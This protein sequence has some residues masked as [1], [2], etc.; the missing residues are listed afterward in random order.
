MK[1]IENG[2][3]PFQAQ[4]SPLFHKNKPTKN[5][6]VIMNIMFK[7]FIFNIVLTNSKILEDLNNK[8]IEKFG[9]FHKKIAKKFIFIGFF[10]N[11]IIV[12]SFSRLWLKYC[13]KSSG[14]WLSFWREIASGK[15]EIL[16][17]FQKKWIK[18]RF[19]E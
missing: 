8:K 18:W 6:K 19:W 5:V 10:W 12:F 17:K 9:K 15:P 14:K 13:E 16:C 3:W 1:K 4:F 11:K 2:H 7:F